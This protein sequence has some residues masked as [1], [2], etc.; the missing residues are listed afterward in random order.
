MHF[1]ERRQVV[2]TTLG[3][4]CFQRAFL[5]GSSVVAGGLLRQSTPDVPDTHQFHGLYALALSLTVNIFVGS[6]LVHPLYKPKQ[7]TDRTT[8]WRN[9]VTMALVMLVPMGFAVGGMAVTFNDSIALLYVSF[10]GILGVAYSVHMLLFKTEIFQWWGIDGNKRKGVAVMGL[11]DG[12]SAVFFTLFT[13]WMIGY[14][15]LEACLYALAGLQ[16]LLSIGITYSI[17]TGRLDQPP[18]PDEFRHWQKTAGLSS[19]AEQS[20]PASRA[21]SNGSSASV[22]VPPTSSSSP[23]PSSAS[24]A[25]L[26]VATGSFS[27]HSEKHDDDDIESVA[28]V[29]VDEEHKSRIPATGTAGE[30][31]TV[32]QPPPGTTHAVPVVFSSRL[33]A[34]KFGP[35]VW[36]CMWYVGGMI[37]NGYS[38]KVS[39]YCFVCVAAAVP[40]IVY[41]ARA[42]FLTIYISC[43]C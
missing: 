34:L 35:V 10:T 13:G 22:P 23:P 32:G 17:R 8:R 7:K 1:Y 25:V 27:I 6:E 16:L 40:G 28:A 4:A 5:C 9:N 31:D 30:A 41:N 24:P 43:R 11:Y 38:T 18:S 42:S 19:S 15:S 33:E 39:G 20:M 29:S 21:F 2:T 36:S 37:F 12:C 26:N 3:V 14:V